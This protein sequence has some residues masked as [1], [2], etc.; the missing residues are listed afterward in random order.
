MSQ[1][2]N[3]DKIPKLIVLLGELTT[4][5]MCKVTKPIACSR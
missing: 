2:G 5:G 1:A 4:T 3:R